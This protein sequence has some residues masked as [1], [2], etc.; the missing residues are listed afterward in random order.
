MKNTIWSEISIFILIPA[1]LLG[2]SKYGFLC[3]VGCSN[4]QTKN[5]DMRY[6]TKDTKNL[7]KWIC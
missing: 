5:K 1:C 3:S 4:N 7:G 2:Q 6:Y